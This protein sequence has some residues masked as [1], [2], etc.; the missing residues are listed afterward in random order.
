[1]GFC[2]FNNV[3][4]AARYAVNR[5][6]CRPC[7]SSTGTCTMGTGHRMRFTRTDRSISF[8]RIDLHFIREPASPTRREPV[9][10]WE[11]FLTCRCGLESPAKSFA[12]GFTTCSNG[13]LAPKPELILISAGF[14]AH[15]ADPIGSLGLESEDFRDLTRLVLDYAGQYLR[16]QTRQP[17]RGGYNLRALAESVEAHVEELTRYLLPNER[18]GGA[19]SDSYVDQE[20]WPGHSVSRPWNHEVDPVKSSFSDR[21]KLRT[22]GRANIK[23]DSLGEGD[24]LHFAPE[25]LGSGHLMLVDAFNDNSLTEAGLYRRDFPA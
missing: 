14:D 5:M 13:P 16:R 12:S 10:D 18:S 25:L 6:V 24:F 22:T 8:R 7:S 23:N 3:A 1:M 11:R 15:R 9:R 19:K 2:L 20:K 17:A 21:D 4:V